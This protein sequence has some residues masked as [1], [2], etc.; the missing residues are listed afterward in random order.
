[1]DIPSYISGQPEERRSL[2]KD[3]HAIIIAH[4]KTV[5]AAIEP[6]MGKEMILYKC[7]GMM[8]YGLASVKNYMS[9]HALPMYGSARL[10]DKY[11]K[12]LPGASFQK[13]CIN[14]SGP[15]EIPLAVFEQLVDDCAPIDLVKMRE[16]YL[17]SKKAAKKK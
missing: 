10:H 15:A 9:F 17:Q 13:G 12:L 11:K 14:F 7:R 8:K 5:S 1:M 6:M 3:M 4:D 2:L 16:A